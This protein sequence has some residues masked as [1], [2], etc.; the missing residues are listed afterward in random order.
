M[1]YKSSF[2][3]ILDANMWWLEWAFGIALFLVF[4]L[5]RELGV[6]WSILF[7]MLGFTV[8]G[9]LTA[10]FF[11]KF[12]I[13]NV[14][15]IEIDADKVRLTRLNQQVLM[16]QWSDFKVVRSEAKCWVFETFDGKKFHIV[17]E[18]FSDRDW[19]A[20]STRIAIFREGIKK[21]KDRFLM[22]G[23][24][25][26]L[27]EVWRSIIVGDEKS[28]V[29]FKN[30]TCVILMESEADLS[31][32][33]LAMMKE[34][35]PVHAGSSAGDFGTIDLKNAPGWVVTSHH[36]DILTYVAPDE[37][38]VLPDYSTD[39]LVGLLGRAKRDQDARELEIVHVEDRR[40][41]RRGQSPKT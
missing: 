17:Q 24:K 38:V 35:G 33:A 40:G 30:G 1:I 16:F 10:F 20:I 25:K 34:C 4:Y 3:N 2:A 9:S 19:L 31:D 11:V 7:R 36:K 12:R 29:L 41:K 28:W 37:V 32:Q 8:V 13:I 6:D 39:L 27:I 21:F 18:C 5:P 26:P 22:E 14:R 23:V 15:E